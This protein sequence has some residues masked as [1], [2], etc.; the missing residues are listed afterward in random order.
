MSSSFIEGNRGEVKVGMQG[1]KEAGCCE[2]AQKRPKQSPKTTPPF[3][4]GAGGILEYNPPTPVTPKPPE[5]CEELRA[6]KLQDTGAGTEHG[7]RHGKASRPAG[8]PRQGLAISRSCGRQDCRAYARNL[9]LRPGSERTSAAAPRMPT[10]F[11]KAA[12]TTGVS[13]AKG[14]IVRFGISLRIA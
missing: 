8:L 1:Q 12:L 11:S 9:R 6:T 13:R 14:L 3:V 2:D 10:S 4:K 7:D 5:R